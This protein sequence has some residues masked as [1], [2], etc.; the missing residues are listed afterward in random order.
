MLNALE[1]PHQGRAPRLGGEPLRLLTIVAV[2][3]LGISGCSKV[4]T[5]GEHT[6]SSLPSRNKSPPEASSPVYCGETIIARHDLPMRWERGSRQG[7]DGVDFRVCPKMP[8]VAVYEGTVMRVWTPDATEDGGGESYYTG[9]SVYLIHRN[10][11]IKYSHLAGV[12]VSERQ[13]VRRGEPLA[14]AWHSDNPAWIPHVHLSVLGAELS[15]EQLDPLVYL[16]GC[17]SVVG[18]DAMIFPVRC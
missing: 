14:D 18:P 3:V 8:V 1:V 2:S 15:D 13:V 9:D 17:E 10:I 12:R 16:E 6:A 5:S 11:T 7:H 4:H